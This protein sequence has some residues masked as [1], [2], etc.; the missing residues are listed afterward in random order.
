MGRLVSRASPAALSDVLG[1][2]SGL[3]GFAVRRSARARR[4]SHCTEPARPALHRY[5]NELHVPQRVMVVLLHADS[6]LSYLSPAL[7]RG[8]PLGTMG[9][10]DHRMCRGFFRALC[11]ARALAAKRVMG[12]GRFRDLSPA[13]VCA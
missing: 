12:T 13:R 9:V 5:S 11:I 2:T 3:S 6:A 4:R 1:R 8:P 7:L 10:S